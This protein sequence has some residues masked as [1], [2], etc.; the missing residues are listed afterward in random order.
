MSTTELFQNLKQAFIYKRKG[1]VQN[2]APFFL[3]AIKFI[4]QTFFAKKIKTSV[5]DTHFGI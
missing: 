5:F 2:A 4:H 3:F 1:T